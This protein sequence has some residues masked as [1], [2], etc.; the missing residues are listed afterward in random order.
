MLSAVPVDAQ[1]AAWIDLLRDLL[2]HSSLR[3]L[4]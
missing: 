3:T 2:A 4:R 1:M